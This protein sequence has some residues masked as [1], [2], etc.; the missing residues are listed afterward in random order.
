VQFQDLPLKRNK[1]IFLK[2]PGATLAGINYADGQQLVLSFKDKIIGKL[3][4]LNTV[5]SFRD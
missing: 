5:E 4:F 3:L 1:W 2:R